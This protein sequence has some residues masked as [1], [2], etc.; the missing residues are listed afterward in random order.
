MFIDLDNSTFISNNKNRRE[1]AKLYDYFTQNI[2]DVLEIQ[3]MKAD[4]IDIKGDGA[5]GLYEGDDAVFKAFAAAVTF[6]TFFMKYIKNKFTTLEEI[7]KMKIS[8]NQDMI[9]V[10]K[11]GRVDYYNEVWAGKLINNAFKIAELNKMITKQD[12]EMTEDLIIVSE[13]IYEKLK[14]KENYTIWSC[15]HDLNGS[16]TNKKRIWTK[17]LDDSQE[18][19]YKE[20]VYYVKSPWCEICGDL[21]RTKILE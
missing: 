6:K 20:P 5:F 15:G 3:D 12:S 18:S 7:L 4:Y 14:L 10:K 2:V 11:I 1:V 9:L 17:F 8:I 21:Y 13:D 16:P 19:D